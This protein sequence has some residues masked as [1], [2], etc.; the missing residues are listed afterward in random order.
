[1]TQCGLAE[2]ARMLEAY[3]DPCVKAF[4]TNWARL[5]SEILTTAVQ[6]QQALRVAPAM[7]A[8]HK[9]LAEMNEE[10]K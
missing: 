7:W 1:M 10:A 9:I 2:L 4:I 5:E 6:R 3:R 8:R